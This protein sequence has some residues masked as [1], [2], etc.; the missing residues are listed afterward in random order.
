MFYLEIWKD[1]KFLNS[2]VTASTNIIQTRMRHLNEFN[3]LRLQ[4]HFVLPRDRP[5]SDCAPGPHSLLFKKHWMN[6]HKRVL[7]P[8]FLE[9]MDYIKVT[10]KARC[11]NY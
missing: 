8:L 7:S 9:G 11:I 10:Y 3:I 1:S 5:A 6:N 2:N 4:R